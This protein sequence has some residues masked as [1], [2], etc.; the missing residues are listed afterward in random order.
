MSNILLTDSAGQALRNEPGPFGVTEPGAVD[1]RAVRTGVAAM[2]AATVVWMMIPVLVKV[3]LRSFDPIVISA[4][5]LPVA[6]ALL[7]LL[8]RARGGRLRDLVP[9]SGWHLF[10]GIALGVNYQLYALGMS[11]TTAGAGTVMI[12]VQIVTLVLLARWILGERLSAIKVAAIA[13]VIAGG[14]LLLAAPGAIDDLTAS[15]YRAGNLV[16]IAASV[17]FGIYGLTS[18]ALAGGHGPGR[19]AALKIAV[20]ILAI[21]AA[22]NLCLLPF[23]RRPD[24][25][26]LEAVAALAALGVIGTAANYALMTRRVPAPVRGDGRHHHGADPVRRDRAG[27]AHPGR[28][29]AG[30]PWSP[31]PRSSPP[32]CWSSCGTSGARPEERERAAGHDPGGDS[33]GAALVAQQA[34]PEHH[35][36]GQR[37]G[38]DPGAEPRHM[39]AESAQSTAAGSAA[40]TTAGSS[41]VAATRTAAGRTVGG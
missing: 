16:M 24:S 3:A 1:R 28:A 26:S 2:L 12:Q 21:A 33:G 38:H 11:L 6:T 35:R 8:H 41:T 29:G 14:G 18:R 31:P 23:A 9:C 4:T 5:R 25:V 30:C 13:C 39:P 36:G 10:G 17:G 19:G 20:P 34:A 27:R 7:A 22:V 40:L 32:P 15:S 37:R